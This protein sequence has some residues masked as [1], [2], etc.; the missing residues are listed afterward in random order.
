MK[1]IIFPLTLCG[2]I[3]SLSPLAIAQLGYGPA[4]KMSK[5]Y[6]FNFFISPEHKTAGLFGPMADR[7]PPTVISNCQG[8]GGKYIGIG[9]GLRQPFLTSDVADVS[10]DGIFRNEVCAISHPPT[11]DLQTYPERL[12]YF[13]AQFQVLRSCTYFE[14]THL[15][16]KTIQFSPHQKFCQLKRLANG[17][18]R[19]EGDF[20]YIQSSP[21][22][23]MA[24]SV[25]LRPECQDENFLR[26]KHLQPTD[27]EALLQAFIVDDQSSIVTENMLGSTKVR[28]SLMPNSQTLEVNP[29]L[30]PELPQFPTQF[31]ADLHQGPITIKDGSFGDDR[32]IFFDLSLFLDTR[33]SRKCRQGIC[34][35]PGDFQVPIAGELEFSAVDGSG[36]KHVLD[37]WLGGNPT[38]A[39]AKTQ[40]Q[41]LF[42]FSRKVSEGLELNIGQTYEI[43]IQFFN[44]YDDYLMLIQGFQQILIDLTLMNGTAGKDFIRPLNALNSLLGLPQVPLLPQLG[45]VEIEEQLEKVRQILQRLGQDQAFPPYYT[46]VCNSALASCQKMNATMKYLT[47]T[48]RFTLGPTS[49][50]NGNYTLLNIQTSRD[51][52]YLPSYERSHQELPELVCQ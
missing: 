27:L 9:L 11:S 10:F 31:A 8:T 39:F 29:D 38:D 41:G 33:S 50:E 22:L 35:G 30:G 24:I 17:K 23:R 6:K 14:F 48:T 4:C 43:N 40:W 2:L 18:V 36:K 44:P 13:Q 15:D 32:K 5:D 34:A 37:S 19:A 51:S 3:I 12:S 7:T 1:K 49:P 46:R 21:D 47:L 25:I 16:Q 28:L 45:S 52:K 26:S 42:R 20:C